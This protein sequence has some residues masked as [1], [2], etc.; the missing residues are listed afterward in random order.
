MLLNVTNEIMGRG[1]GGSHLKGDSRNPSTHQNITNGNSSQVNINNNHHKNATPSFLRGD[2]VSAS[3]RIRSKK[4]EALLNGGA[5]Q[6]QNVCKKRNRHSG[7]FSFFNHSSSTKN[8]NVVA[9]KSISNNLGDVIEG[10]RSS[11]ETESQ[12]AKDGGGD[13]AYITFP[14]GVPTVRE[15]KTNGGVAS[16][17]GG[18]SNIIQRPDVTNVTNGMCQAQPI[19]VV[20]RNV[21]GMSIPFNNCQQEISMNSPSS[22]YSDIQEVQSNSA[23]RQFPPVSNSAKL[24]AS[25]PFS[26]SN[27]GNNMS[28]LDPFSRQF[29]CMN[30]S[31]K[32]MSAD[33][34]QFGRVV[35]NGNSNINPYIQSPNREQSPFLIQQPSRIVNENGVVLRNKPKNFMFNNNVRYSRI[36]EEQITGGQLKNQP[37]PPQYVT[38]VT[39]GQPTIASASTSSSSSITTSSQ[40][41]QMQRPNVLFR[42]KS[43]QP[44]PAGT[45]ALLAGAAKRCS[46]EFD[47]VRNNRRNAGPDF[48]HYGFINSNPIFRETSVSQPVTPSEPPISSANG[49]SSMIYQS[50]PE[51]QEFAPIRVQVR[52]DS[53][54]PQIRSENTNGTSTF[55]STK[56]SRSSSS[57][58]GGNG[59]PSSRRRSSAS[60]HHQ[61]QISPLAETALN[62]ENHSEYVGKTKY[63][64]QPNSQPANSKSSQIQQQ[65]SYGVLNIDIVPNYPLNNQDC[66]NSSSVEPVKLRQPRQTGLGRRAVTQI[67]IQQKKKDSYNSAVWKSQENLVQVSFNKLCIFT[68]VNNRNSPSK[69][70]L[71]YMTNNLTQSCVYFQ[72]YS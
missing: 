38:K 6:G 49:F 67:H 47:F 28:I 22:L 61:Q 37:P 34:S 64:E 66:V 16:G 2:K 35:F 14:N 65:Q 11:S 43:E 13:W 41:F 63:D 39:L 60:S 54:P 26:L 33:F 1:G 72:S 10:D 29:R 42:R 48:T 25:T 30:P 53:S 7:D 15:I 36:V 62:G 31:S 24:K 17:A 3:V 45:A 56:S 44:S 55:G 23:D 59:T 58:A 40:P 71:I 57:H 12:G 46:G 9:S 8:V 69:S 70:K 5:A 18:V 68:Y 19:K 50:V 21:P 32:R 27:Q 52:S 51:Q 20:T 4:H